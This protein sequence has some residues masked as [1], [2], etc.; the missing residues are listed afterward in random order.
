M[1]RSGWN[2]PAER[3]PAAPPLVAVVVDDGFGART[4]ITWGGGDS[5]G[6]CRR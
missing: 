4:L 3:C 6:S 1:V 5:M 2:E